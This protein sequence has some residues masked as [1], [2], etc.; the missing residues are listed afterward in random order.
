MLPSRSTRPSKGTNLARS[1]E[2]SQRSTRVWP[3]HSDLEMVHIFLVFSILKVAAAP[4]PLSGLAINGN[5]IFF[6]ALSMS[7]SV[8]T[9]APGTTGTPAFL[10][11]FFISDLNLVFF[12]SFGLAPKTLNCSRSAASN[13]NQYSLWDSIR[14]IGPCL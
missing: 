9:T 12:R 10:K 8:L 13:S 6:T 7:F 5:P 11:S 1:D 14:S 2:I 3:S 4:T